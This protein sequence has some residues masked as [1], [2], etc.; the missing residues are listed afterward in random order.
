MMKLKNCLGM[1][2]GHRKGKKKKKRKGQEGKSNQI[3]SDENSFEEEKIVL[4]KFSIRQK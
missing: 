4:N 2:Q 1:N 3:K